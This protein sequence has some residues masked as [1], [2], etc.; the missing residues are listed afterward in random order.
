VPTGMGGTK[1][2]FK[3]RTTQIEDGPFLR[4]DHKT[5]TKWAWPGSRDSISKFWDPY[6]FRTIHFKFA[7]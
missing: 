7:I 5:I 3:Y 4:M 6:N 1:C 2:K